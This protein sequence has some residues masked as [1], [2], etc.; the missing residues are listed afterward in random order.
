MCIDILLLWYYNTYEHLLKYSISNE[1]GYNMASKIQPA[2]RCD[3]DVIH[4]GTVNQVREK[5]PQEETL[6]DLAELFK[7]FGDS[8]RIKIL[9]ALDEAEMCVC[10]IAFLLNMTQSAISHQLRVLKQ[11]ELVKSRREGK[12]VFYS[13]EDEH[14]KQIFDQGLIHISE[15][16]K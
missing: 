2:E 4:E 10:D 8:T 1:G 7:V 11:A 16:R 13:L 14:V 12:I 15:E 6:Y 3:C 5:M 9:W